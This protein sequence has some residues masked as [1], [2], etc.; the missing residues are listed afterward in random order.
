VRRRRTSALLIGLLVSAPL[1]LAASPVTAAVGGPA[2]PY[3]IN[4]DGFPELVASADYVTVDGHPGAGAVYLLSGSKNGLSLT[5]QVVTETTGGL[6]DADERGELFGFALTSADFDRD[7]YADLAVGQVGAGS[8]RA[9]DTGKVTVFYGGPR[10]LDATRATVLTRPGAPFPFADFGWSLA[11]ADLDDDGYADLAVGAPGDGG[12]EP[13]D[14]GKIGGT[15]TLFYGGKNGLRTTGARLLRGERE[16]SK[17]DHEFGARLA[18][19]D[20]DND[21]QD[22]LVVGSEGAGF[23]DGEGHPGSV[24][25]CPSGDQ[26][27]TACVQLVHGDAYAGIG[28]IGVG[29]VNGSSR[30]EI[31]V[32]V[33]AAVEESNDP[34]KVVVLSVDGVRSARVSRKLTITQNSRGVPGSNEPDDAFGASIALGDLDRDGFDDLVVGVEREDDG[35]KQNTGRVAL[36]YGAKAGYR[37]NGNKLYSQDTKGVPSAAKAGEVF[38]AAVTLIDHDADGHLDLAV[39]APADSDGAVT[40][41]KGKGTSFETKGSKT[42]RLDT[43]DQSPMPNLSAPGFGAVLGQ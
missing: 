36:V 3:D 1:A 43:L 22:D 35:T 27:P 26:G 23:L 30:A 34:G 4:G 11:A 33:P 37:T 2:K 32:G 21:G 29:N 17:Q 5:P 18:V 10:G 7:G 20:V 41:L 19:G 40:T 14:Q 38:G 42:F 15:V 13:S 31:V 25:Y 16:G 8:G 12:P 39:G 24:S 28:A 9:D 6:V